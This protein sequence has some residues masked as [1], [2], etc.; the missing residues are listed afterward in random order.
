MNDRTVPLLQLQ[1]ITVDFD[2]E[3]VVKNVDFDLFPG[4]IHAIVGQRKAGKSTLVKIISGETRKESGTIL[5]NGKEINY[6][7]PKSRI[8]H[9]IGIV[10]QTSDIITSINAV[11]FIYAGRLPR[12]F[13]FPWNYKNFEKKSAEIFHE[14]DI[15]IDLKTPTKNLSL[16]EQHFVEVARALSMGPSILIF[17]EISVKLNSDEIRKLFRYLRK[18]AGEGKG[19][20]YVTSN[21]DEIFE[22]ADRVTVLK[23]GYRRETTEVKNVDRYKL[24][25][26]AYNLWVHDETSQ[27]SEAGLEYL[28]SYN[29]DILKNL[30]IGIVLLDTSHKVYLI[31]QTARTCLETS[32]KIIKGTDVENLLPPGMKNREEIIENIYTATRKEY[33]IIAINSK[34]PVKLRTFPLRDENQVILGTTVVLEEKQ[35]SDY[36]EEYVVQAEKYETIAKLA[37][38]VAHE[39]KNPLEIIK[40]YVTLLSYKSYDEDGSVKLQKIDKELIRIEE[41]VNSLLSFSRV[42]KSSTDPVNITGLIKEI[43]ILINHMIREKKLTFNIDTDSEDITVA[44]ND[45]K[46]KQLILNLI[47]NSIEAVMNG[48]RITTRISADAKKRLAEITIEDNGYGI[49]EELQQ[50]I[51]TPFFTTKMSKKNTGLGLSICQSIVE[52]HKGS[53]DFTS[54]PGKKTTF[55]IRLP[56]G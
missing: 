50:E 53:I 11:D 17:D 6:L 44:G 27:E 49:P 31:N 12:P 45:N 38:G 51:F 10:R 52:S 16:G 21:I 5:L 19:I 3:D 23:N 25:R 54:V 8:R 42:K 48:G 13:V 37:A 39:I 32:E 9:G 28:Q 47:M 34:T 55:T 2:G 4:E 40:N 46:L 18:I 7:T 1:N 35:T 24:L 43:K 20:I 30:S 41:I 22:I 56:L 36:I 14:L 29:D 26:M 33:E 15:D